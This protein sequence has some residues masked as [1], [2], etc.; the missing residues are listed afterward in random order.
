MHVL[1]VLRD[2]NVPEWQVF[3]GA[4]YQRVFNHQTGRDLDYGIKDYDVGY[5]DADTSY[6]AE[7]AVIHRVAAAFEPPL[8]DLVEVRNQA[9]VHLWFP[10]KFGEPYEPL[11][12]SS[13]ALGRFVSPVFAVAVSLEADDRLMICAPFGLQDLFALR[14][15]QNPYRRSPNFDRIAEGALARWPELEVIP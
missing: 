5:F 14:M 10:D 12:S 3:S 4:V 15:R 1:R 9:R 13:E 2:L 8:R 11:T 6:D 7:D